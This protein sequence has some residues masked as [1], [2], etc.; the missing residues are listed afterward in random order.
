M[1]IDSTHAP[2]AFAAVAM[3]RTAS[4][5][6]ARAAAGS[7]SQTSGRRSAAAI[8]MASG[9]SRATKAATACASRTS[10]ATWRGP[11]RL[12]AVCT[13]C[14]PV[15]ASSSRTSARPSRP[16]APMTATLNMARPASGGRALDRVAG[17]VDGGLEHVGAL[18]RFDAHAARGQVDLDLGGGVLLV[19]RARDGADAVLAAHAFDV[20]LDHDVFLC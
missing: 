17:F 15:S 4:T 7:C 8:T 2:R 9:A 6:S 1:E 18:G 14:Q 12:C 11:T 20:E 16:D 5:L 13:T 10:S 19:D 3:L